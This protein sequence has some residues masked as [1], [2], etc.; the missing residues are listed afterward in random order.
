MRGSRMLGHV[1]RGEVVGC[2]SLVAGG[3]LLLHWG[4]L[5]K[6][7]GDPAGRGGRSGR[8]EAN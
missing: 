5:R 7:S 1:D 2:G 8:F 4:H 3:L 6:G